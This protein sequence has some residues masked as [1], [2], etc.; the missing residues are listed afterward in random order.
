MVDVCI[1]AAISLAWDNISIYQ[2][3]VSWKIGGYNGTE[4]DDSA[5]VAARHRHQTPI[6]YHLFREMLTDL[7]RYMPTL[8]P[9]LTIMSETS[10]VP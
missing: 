8:L 1:L 2:N 6:G 3:P 10:N 4:S 7:L 5:D 9:F